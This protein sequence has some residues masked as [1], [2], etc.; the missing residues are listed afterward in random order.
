MNSV[1][2]KRKAL[3]E[4]GRKK[5]CAPL[6][7]SF[8]LN[9]IGYEGYILPAYRRWAQTMKMAYYPLSLEREREGVRVNKF[10]SPHLHPLP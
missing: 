1:G 10:G 9:F 2:I 6:V 5:E 8:Y 4:P 3:S 7:H